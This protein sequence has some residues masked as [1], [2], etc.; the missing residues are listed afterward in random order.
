MND[1]IGAIVDA[2]MT[3][4][5]YITDRILRLAG[6]GVK[7]N[8]LTM[9]SGSDNFRQSSILGAMKRIKAKG[10]EV[11]V[12]GPALEAEK[13]FSARVIRDLGELRSAC[14]V[15]VANRYSKIEDVYTRDLF[16]RD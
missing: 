2:N 9:K 11:A 6:F 16:F 10:V 12:Y 13:L 1:I 15:I 14:G 4:K 7:K 8:R 3:R 5:D